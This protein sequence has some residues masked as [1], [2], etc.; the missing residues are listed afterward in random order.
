MF[1]IFLLDDV[2]SELDKNRQKLLTT[3]FS[4]YQISYFL[5]VNP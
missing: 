3:H 4:S 5:R 2:F 1:K